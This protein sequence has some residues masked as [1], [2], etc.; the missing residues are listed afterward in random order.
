MPRIRTLAGRK[1]LMEWST[2]YRGRW[3][4]VAHGVV[5]NLQRPLEGSGSWSG[6]QPTEPAGRKWLM[7]W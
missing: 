1:W 3:K 4:E 7:E 2:T 6:E 5:N